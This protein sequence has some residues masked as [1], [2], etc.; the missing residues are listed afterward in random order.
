MPAPEVRFC[1]CCG[2]A[3]ATRI[4]PT[5]DRERA[6]CTA[7]GYIDYINPNN[8]VGTL[9]V[10]GGDRSGADEP[11]QHWRGEQ[12][13]LCRRAIEPRKGL[14]TLPAGFLEYGETMAEGAVRET[15]EEAG[16]RIELGPLSTVLD[17]PHVGQVHVFYL[18]RLLDLD[19]D[20]GPETTENRLVALDEI[21]WDELAFHTV[22]RTLSH[23]VDDCAS[24][25]FAVHTGAIELPPARQVQPDPARSGPAVEK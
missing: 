2:A 11:E 9:P 13:L 14:W 12:I 5:E 4:P 22:R 8:V 6:V 18:A 25:V 10:W 7:C 16:A 1:R 17:V 23:Y 24:G 20:P 3:T 19:L 15:R 21:P